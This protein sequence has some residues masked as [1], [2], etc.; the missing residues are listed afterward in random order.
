MQAYFSEDSTQSLPDLK[1]NDPDYVPEPMASEKKVNVTTYFKGNLD[2]IAAEFER[3]GIGKEAIAR[4]LTLCNLELYKQ[5]YIDKPVVFPRSRIE[6]SV[7][8]DGKRRVAE[9]SE[10]SPVGEYNY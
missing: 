9:L 5:G 2:G 1:S 6:G 8:R 3:S 7:A 10:R 4:T